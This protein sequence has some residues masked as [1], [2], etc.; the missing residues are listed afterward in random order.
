MSLDDYT[1]EQYAEAV[2]EWLQD[3]P[4]M[5]TF[6]PVDYPYPKPSRQVSV[7]LKFEIDNPALYDQIYHARRASWLQSLAFTVA[8]LFYAYIRRGRQR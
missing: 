3:V 6:R 8:N 1:P 7:P 4:P 5:M 2:D